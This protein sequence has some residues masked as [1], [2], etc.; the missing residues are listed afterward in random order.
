LECHA[1]PYDYFRFTKHS[2]DLLFTQQG[3]KINELSPIGGAY[4]A[5]IQ[6]KMISIGHRNLPKTLAYFP[7]RIIRKIYNLVAIPIENWKAINFDKIFWNDKL[8]LNYLVI[9]SKK[10][11]AP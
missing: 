7:Y 9:V 11:L 8:C 5:L 4:A 10:D 6:M 1:E 3:F 2:L